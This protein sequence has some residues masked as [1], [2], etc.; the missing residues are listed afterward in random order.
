MP[1]CE[2]I[3]LNYYW[4]GTDHRVDNNTIQLYF[5]PQM[6]INRD[7]SAT[8]NTSK[9]QK[10]IKKKTQTKN[11]SMWSIECLCVF[12]IY[13]CGGYWTPPSKAYSFIFYR[14]VIS[15]IHYVIFADIYKRIYSTIH[16]CTW[17]RFVVATAGHNVDVQPSSRILF[18]SCVCIY[19]YGMSI[20]RTHKSLC[21]ST[22]RARTHP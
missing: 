10:Y 15:R 6:R 17:V 11:R 21:P 20:A 2:V 18:V 9:I 13:N 22:I 16:V 12:A 1:L 8:E 19:K 14:N 5:I 4:D 7:F 3:K